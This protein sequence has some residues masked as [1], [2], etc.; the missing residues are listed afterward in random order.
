MNRINRE[1]NTHIKNDKNSQ[2]EGH[3]KIN[4]SIVFKLKIRF[5][6]SVNLTN[7]SS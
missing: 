3:G 6:A 5:I 2:R 4:I 7:S 1:K